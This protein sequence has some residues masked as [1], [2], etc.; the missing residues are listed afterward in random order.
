[1][2]DIDEIERS[3][4]ALLAADP[5]DY[6]TASREY[7]EAASA[8]NVLPLTTELRVLR[9]DEARLNFSIERRTEWYPG[10]AGKGYGILCYDL[11]GQRAE[12]IGLT[13]RGAIDAARQKVVA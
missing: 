12:A 1:M 10:R 4:R 7:R 3:A 9:E 6:E 5:D 2:T 13:M 11:N 8:A